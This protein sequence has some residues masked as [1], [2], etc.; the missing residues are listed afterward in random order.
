MKS[1]HFTS[2]SAKWFSLQGECDTMRPYNNM[3]IKGQVAGL[4]E[5]SEK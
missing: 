5:V 1:V 3:S 2:L 4:G